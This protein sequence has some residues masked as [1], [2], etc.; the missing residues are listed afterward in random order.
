M[1]RIDLMPALAVILEAHP[2]RHG[3][4]IGEALPELLVAGDL[5]ADVADYPAEPDAQEFQRPPGTLELMGVAIAPDHDRGALGHPAIALPQL[6]VVALR[7]VHE[8]FE[9]PVA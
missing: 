2:M 1:Q 9:R 8:F 6:H 5:A 7:Q 3:E 4:E